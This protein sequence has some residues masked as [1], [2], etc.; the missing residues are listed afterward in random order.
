MTTERPTGAVAT[1][2]SGWLDFDGWARRIGRYAWCEQRLFEL[3]GRWSVEVPEAEACVLLARQARRRA[4]HAARWDGLLPTVAG[5][6]ATELVRPPDGLDDL[7]DRLGAGSGAPTTV[8]RLAAVGHVVG[9]GLLEVYADHRAAA[10]PIAEGPTIEVLDAVLVEQGE[11]VADGQDLL[12]RIDPTG[13]ATER[14]V[15]GL[16]ATWRPGLR[17]AW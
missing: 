3:L 5:R 13:A 17:E 7:G 9:P 2:S 8:E 10:S 11:D 12:A 14:A 1:P 6:P 15:A 16:G 4:R